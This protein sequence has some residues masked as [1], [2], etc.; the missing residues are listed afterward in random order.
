MKLILI[1]NPKAH[2]QE[3]VH[4]HPES[5]IANGGLLSEEDLKRWACDVCMA[6][7]SADKPILVVGGPEGYSLCSKCAKRYAG[8]PVQNCQCAGCAECARCLVVK[9]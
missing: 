4:S 3:W 2:R 1:P 6:P 5:L 7:I 9:E 8:E